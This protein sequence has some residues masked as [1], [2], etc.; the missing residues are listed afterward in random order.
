M[1]F[2][3]FALLLSVLVYLV[4]SANNILEFIPKEKLEE[5]RLYPQLLNLSQEIFPRVK[6]LFQQPES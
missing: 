5:S 1:T 6:E 3:L 4:D 2:C